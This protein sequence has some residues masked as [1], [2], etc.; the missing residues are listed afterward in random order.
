[1]TV[2]QVVDPGVS[3][4]KFDREVAAYRDL[5]ATY[6][7]RGWLLLEAKFPEVFVAFAATKLKPAPIV[8]AVILDFT[9]YDLQPP[10][11]RFVDPF[12]RE[13]LLASNVGF[14]MFRRPPMPGVPPEMIAAMIQQGAIQV[15]G[16]LQANRPDDYPFLCLPGVRE[17]HDNPAH[18]GDSWLLHRGS[19][20]GSLAFILEKIWTY[21]S[22]PISAYNI[23]I[24]AQV[25]GVIPNP[26]GIPE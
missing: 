5:E 8:A 7:K 19:G 18:T 24:Q 10:S 4:A 9:D 11:V 3:G 17:Y 1:M 25:Q 12:T 26:Q 2:P 14:Q 23:Q 16:L 15:S 22:D 6:R 21:G 20:E 13:K